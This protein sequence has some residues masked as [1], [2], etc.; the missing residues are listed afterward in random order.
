[1][2]SQ[3]GCVS[4]PA[5]TIEKL[6]YGKA[7]RT[8]EKDMADKLPALAEQLLANIPRL[9]E[10]RAILVNQSKH[11]DG[12]GGPA[13][14][15]AGETIP[16]GSRILKI[17]IDYDR[18]EAQGLSASAALDTMRSHTGW[19]DPKLLETFSTL[20]GAEAQV[21]LS[22]LRGGEA[23]T[24]LRTVRGVLK[25]LPLKLVEVGMTFAE[26]LRTQG[27]SLLVARGQ[28]VTESLVERI[29]NLS[30]EV[31]GQRIRI[32]TKVLPPKPQVPN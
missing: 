16:L 21:P 13:N 23:Q 19:Y 3:V 4:L 31:A 30:P 10:V 32:I 1:M 2:M 6:Y 25:E 7:L 28:E 22:T 15:L 5:E 17:A 14:G 26:D 12:T 27:G 9:E 11:F 8:D 24:P 29:R 20:R 18:L